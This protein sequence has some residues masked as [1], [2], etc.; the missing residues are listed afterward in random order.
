MLQQ[1]MDLVPPVVLPP[2]FSV[3]LESLDGGMS[4]ENG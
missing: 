2:L 3:A 1:F 4:L